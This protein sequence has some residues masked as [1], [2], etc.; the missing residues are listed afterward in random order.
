VT[1]IEASSHYPGRAYVTASG[2][3][4]DDLKPYIHVTDDFGRTWESLAGGLPDEPVNV[5]REDRKNPNLLFI[6]TERG[7]FVS[8]DAGRNWT[9]LRNNL[10]SISV[11]DLAIHPRE[12]DLIVGTHGRGFYITDISPLQELTP[13][14]L[15]EDVHLFDPEPRVQWRIISQPTRSAQNFSGENEPL[16][17][18]VNYFLKEGKPGGVQVGVYEGDRLLQEIDGPGEQGMNR[19][20]WPFTWKRERTPEEKE[21]FKEQRGIPSDSEGEWGQE[22]F[23]YYDQLVWYG[24]EDSEVSVQGRSL[25]TRRH[26][27][28]WETDPRFKYTRVRPGTY[29]IVLRAGG[30]FVSKSALVLKDNWVKEHN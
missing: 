15:A 5:I 4:W 13:D 30:R 3:R 6:G 17:V 1:R 29:R 12:N 8:I 20:V 28:D 18:V 7:V 26:I 19:V 9:R 27:N 24:S 21:A 22:Y 2:L 16:G 11:H 23:D 25:M 14:V 10:P